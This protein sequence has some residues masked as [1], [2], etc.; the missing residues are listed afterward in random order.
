MPNW[1]RRQLGRC[2]VQWLYAGAV[3]QRRSNHDCKDRTR[4]SSAASRGLGCAAE[5]VEA[6]WPAST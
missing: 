1:D 3:R 5:G 6:A 2:H 4:A